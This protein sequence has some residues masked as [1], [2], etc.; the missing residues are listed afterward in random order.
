VFA[1]EPGGF[2][3]DLANSN[4]IVDIARAP[5]FAASGTMIVPMRTGRLAED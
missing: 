4:Q 2:F 3:H 5:S 1:G